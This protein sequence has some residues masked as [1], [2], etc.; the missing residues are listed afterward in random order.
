[1]NQRRFIQ[2]SWVAACLLPT[3]LIGTAFLVVARLGDRLG[4]PLQY[5]RYHAA[6]GGNSAEVFSHWLN[7]VLM[8]GNALGLAWLLTLRTL[9]PTRRLVTFARLAAS[10]GV[11]LAFV[12]GGS[13]DQQRGE[14][15][16]LVAGAILFLPMLV[17]SYYV[18]F[19]L[20]A[21]ARWK[22]LRVAALSAAYAAIHV[23]AQ[24]RYEPSETGGPN[25]Q[26]FVPW[27][28]WNSTALIW[29]LANGIRR[30]AIQRFL[31]PVF[32]HG[33]RRVVWLPL[34]GLVLLT[35]LAATTRAW[36]LREQWSPDAMRRL[37][38]V[39]AGLTQV[40][41]AEL[42]QTA[43][44]PGNGRQL[45]IPGSAAELLRSV[46]SPTNDV[47]LYLPLTN[48]FYLYLWADAAGRDYCDVRRM[49]DEH[50]EQLDQ[51]FI[52]AVLAAG[53]THETWLYGLLWS[54]YMAGR[55]I[56]DTRGEIT[57]IAILG[58]P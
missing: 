21:L 56:K 22:P 1:M 58:P 47:R 3:L 12:V 25:S 43:A 4:D 14:G 54:P 29:A 53:G 57:A 48:G 16:V 34:T 6:W 38:A 15:T 20:A 24:L 33:A 26:V 11:V 7:L 9:L 27:L 52:D 28:F 40:V 30:G 19:Q 10:F 13:L 8:S 32:H 2:A 51:G 55:V 42:R 46:V 31:A 35:I 44:Q 36:R 17:S 41:L 45:P 5:Q 49:K 39:E 23:L 37:D 50:T 18:L